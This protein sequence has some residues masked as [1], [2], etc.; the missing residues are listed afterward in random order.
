MGRNGNPPDIQLTESK[1]EPDF[2]RNCL[3][4]RYWFCVPEYG[5]DF[6][7]LSKCDE[8]LEMLKREVEAALGRDLF[9]QARCEIKRVDRDILRRC[10][11]VEIVAYMSVKRLPNSLRTWLPDV[12]MD[13]LLSPLATPKAYSKSREEPKPAGKLL[14]VNTKRKINIQ[15]MDYE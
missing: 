4:A 3:L 10:Y 2:D 14:P 7:R 9:K 8:L 11:N 15:G 5:F 6:S 1:Y 13:G 12:P